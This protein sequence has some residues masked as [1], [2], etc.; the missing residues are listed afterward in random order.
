MLAHIPPTVTT[1][2]SGA[3]LPSCPLV[4]GQRKASMLDLAWRESDMKMEMRTRPP[5]P[6]AKMES[7]VDT[8][9]FGPVCCWVPLPRQSSL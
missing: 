2:T 4:K 3:L 1:S 9:Q 6:G 8:H 7:S 5:L